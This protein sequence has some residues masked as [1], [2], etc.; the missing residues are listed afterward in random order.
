MKGKDNTWNLRMDMENYPA[1]KNCI[2]LNGMLSEDKAS[3]KWYTPSFGQA[4]GI[5]VSGSNTLKT[6]PNPTYWTS[7]TNGTD[8]WGIEVWTGKNTM[9]GLLASNSL[10]C[11]R[12]I[13]P[14]ET[15]K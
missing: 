8:A 4:L 11:I 13:D 10:R 12:D 15:V 14:T 7:T 9:I 3:L 5:Y 6:L 2:K 1:I